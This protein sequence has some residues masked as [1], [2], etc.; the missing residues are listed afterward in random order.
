[1]LVLRNTGTRYARF[2][3]LEVQVLAAAGDSRVIEGIALARILR[4]DALLPGARVEIAPEALGL[5]AG[6]R[7][8]AV[9]LR[10]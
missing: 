3:D 5:A 8:A 6:E 2:A 1:V 7:V 4:T 9:S 10:P